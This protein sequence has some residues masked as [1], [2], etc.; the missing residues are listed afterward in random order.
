MFGTFDANLG[1]GVGAFVLQNTLVQ[2]GSSYISAT[3][4][5]MISVVVLV[6]HLRSMVRLQATSVCAYASQT[7]PSACQQRSEAEQAGLLIG[8]YSK[9][10]SQ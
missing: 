10:P 5:N 8:S 3:R 6:I 2:F 1:T 7:N 9:I 4:N